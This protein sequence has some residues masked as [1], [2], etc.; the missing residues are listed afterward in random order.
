MGACDLYQVNGN[1]TIIFQ[2]P[3]SYIELMCLTRGMDFNLIRMQL[4]RNVRQ[5]SC[6]KQGE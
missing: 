5:L 1:G 6:W 2:E 4:P 3:A